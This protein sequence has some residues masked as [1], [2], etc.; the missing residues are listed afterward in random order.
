MPAASEPASRVSPLLTEK[1][2]LPLAAL[3]K[4]LRL[5]VLPGGTEKTMVS[6]AA[7]AIRSPNVPLVAAAAV[8]ASLA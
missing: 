7:S 2:V 1:K 4:P 8:R 3:R 6:A 5:I